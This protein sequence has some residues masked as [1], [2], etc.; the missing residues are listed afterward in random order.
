MH[1][2]GKIPYAQTFRGTIIEMR[3]GSPIWYPV[4]ELRQKSDNKSGQRIYRVLLQGGIRVNFG[5]PGSKAA[6]ISG[7][8]KAKRNG[9][10]SRHM[11]AEN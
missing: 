2:Q 9:D 7:E 1:I 6:E 8:Q 3:R 4:R 11:V 5:C 10:I